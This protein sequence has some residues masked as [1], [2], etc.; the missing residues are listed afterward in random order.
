MQFLLLPF[1]LCIVSLGAFGQGLILDGL[2]TEFTFQPEYNRSVGF[3][4]EFT[5]AG[6]LVIAESYTAQ[7]GIALGQTGKEFDLDIMLGA[8][9]RLPLPIDLKVR[10]MYLYST[11]P[12]YRYQANSLLPYLSYRGKWVGADL[13]VTLRF[14]AFNEEPA[15]FEP[16]FSARIFANILN[17]DKVKLMAGIGNFSSFRI[18]NLGDYYLFLGNRIAVNRKQEG[19]SDQQQGKRSGLRGIARP[20]IFLINDFN[21]YQTGSS[22]LAST[23]QGVAWRGGVGLSW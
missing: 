19:G 5:A 22:G 6:E 17:T 16:V 1:L 12:E 10:T 4:Y 21:L 2:E 9:Y 15:I 3:C 7:A 11:I 18:G 23:L 14:T 20:L 8:A 13:G